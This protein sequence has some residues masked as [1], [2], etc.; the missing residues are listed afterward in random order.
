MRRLLIVAN[1]LPLTVKEADGDK[2]EYKASAGGLATGLASLETEYEKHWI[3]WPGIHPKD[4]ATKTKIQQ[5]LEKDNIHSVFL[6]EHAVD[7]YYK[8]FSN[9]T[10][11]PLFHYFGNNVEF[12]P[13][14]WQVYQEVNEQ[15]C[16]EVMKIAQPNDIIWV[17]DYQLMLLPKML[18]EKLPDAE[19]GFFLHIPF[20]SYEIFRT[21]TWRKQILE[22]LLGS[23]LIGLHTSDYMRHF[24]SAVYRVL[25]QE[26]ELGEIDLGIRLVQV[27]T[28]PMGIDYDKFNQ[29]GQSEKVQ[30]ISKEFR[31]QFGDRKLV[32]SVDRLD[33]SK[34][35]LQRLKAFDQFLHKNKEFSEQVSLIL[36]VVPSRDDIGDYATLKEEIDQ[37]VGNI[38]GNHATI[39][40][41][42]INYFYRSLP[43]DQLCALY[44]IA[45]VAL[46][47]P[48]R[49]GMNLVAKEFV[50][51]KTNNT[52]VLI[53]SEMAGA[54]VEL[55]QSLKINPND[56]DDI[57]S[58]L[59]QALRM[60]EHEQAERL[61]SMQQHLKRHTVQYW[62]NK[63]MKQLTSVHKEQLKRK[64]KEFGNEDCKQLLSNFR[65]SR[66]R[67]ILLDY[68]GTL[69]PLVERP[70]LAAP[71]QQLLD[72][73]RDLNAME[74]TTVVIISGRH[75]LTLDE[76]FE[77]LNVGLIAE[78]G[79]WYRQEGEWLQTT[80]PDVSWK[81]E[82]YS[83]LQDVTDKTPGAFVE[84]KPYSLAWHYRKADA[85]IADL[86]ANGLIKALVNPCTDNN[87]QILTGHKVVE[88]KVSGMDKGT[89]TKHWLDK[90]DWDFVLAAGDDR[91]DEDMFRVLP[92]S[93][94]SIR[95]GYYETAARFN[96]ETD[97][98]VRDLLKLLLKEGSS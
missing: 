61:Q 81:K 94:Y 60:T 34:G 86:R 88:V 53:L 93:A 97:Q 71:T 58:T 30:D 36:V 96:V 68:D 13:E 21:L 76:W 5:T 95:V 46:L 83:I 19:I 28:F 92:Q 15:F 22:G 70:E 64:K 17:H 77:K 48:F 40:W 23:D 26:S 49:D 84:E 31:E 38:D 18:R 73:I 51:T 59:E 6:T 41:K 47:T 67:L 44:H 90:K 27:D 75:H 33:Y 50:A 87:L 10:I 79:S 63:F 42:P 39:N 9:S 78:H 74:N 3:G 80:N 91:T 66:Q 82:I 20:P 85:W 8:G 24:L 54:A 55:P 32:L 89:G 56:L 72:L 4:D 35:I 57:V 45:D 43:F 11:W 65:G 62:A 7:Y 1:R 16:E 25:G 52:G 2:V 12:N 37:M 69:T 29:S 14:Y 98:D